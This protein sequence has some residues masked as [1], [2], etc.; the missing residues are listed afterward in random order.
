MIYTHHDTRTVTDKEIKRQSET[1]NEYTIFHKR[2]WVK[3]K[4]FLHSVLAHEGIS[5]LV[6]SKK[7]FFLIMVRAHKEKQRG[8]ARDRQRQRDKDR[9]METERWMKGDRETE[10]QRQTD[11][12]G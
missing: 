6:I 1:I 9:Q 12:E 5:H 11:R 8:G 3:L 2:P 7:I 10:R 4:V